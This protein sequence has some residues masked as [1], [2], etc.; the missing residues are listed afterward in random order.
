VTDP[1][2]DPPSHGQRRYQPPTGATSFLLVRHGA[3]E[4]YV[5]GVPFPLAHGHGDPALD[6]LGHEQ[7]R[8]LVPRLRREQIAA[9]Y[10]SP[11]QRTA[12]TIAP[13]L[14]ATGR[15]AEVIH[16]L[17]EVFLGEW[18]GGEFRARFAAGDPRAL[19][20]F[21]LGEWGEIP[22]GESSSALEA[23]CVAVLLDLHARHAGERVLCVA[24]GAVIGALC[25]WAT[26]SA[27]NYHWGAENASI[28]ELIVLG[29]AG[30]YRRL[31]LFNDVSHLDHD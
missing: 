24:H 18:E 15:T 17:R 19:N 28:H 6:P 30:E 26:G 7:A 11:L 1:E 25:R 3:S 5:E 22:G 13:Y 12:Q 14:A 2:N 4:P 29:P 23:R 10:I 16:D 20:A 21:S 27:A 31:H 8:R 9:V